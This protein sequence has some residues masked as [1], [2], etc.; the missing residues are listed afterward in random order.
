M[1]EKSKNSEK[2]K[3]SKKKG[4]LGKMNDDKKPDKDSCKE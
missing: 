4:I 1:S 2:K 3:S